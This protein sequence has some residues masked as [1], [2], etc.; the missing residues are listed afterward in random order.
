MDGRTG[1]ESDS[2]NTNILTATKKGELFSI[3]HHRRSNCTQYINVE[4]GI[5][6]QNSSK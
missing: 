2:K 3:I 4:E 5:K 6:V 1:V